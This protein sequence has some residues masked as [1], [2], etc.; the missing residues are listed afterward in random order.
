M[1]RANI[2]TIADLPQHPQNK[3]KRGSPPSLKL[4]ETPPTKIFSADASPKKAERPLPPPRQPNTALR[5]REHLTPA[6]VELLI[7]VARKRGRYGHRDA[8]AILI[9]YTHGLRISELVTLTWSQ[10]DFAEGVIHVR[11]LKGSR[12]STQPLRGS[13]IRALRQLRREWP[14][15]QFLFQTERGGPMTGDNFRKML[16]AAGKAAGFPWLVHPHMLRHACGYKL[17]N[18]GT[19]I[20]T[21]QMYLGHKSISSTAIYTELAADRFNGLWQD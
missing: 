13:E 7:S 6:E 12:P 21:I 19:D 9:A 17:V 18:Q 11:R 15:G 8:T 10:I 3:S 1:A 20:R 4:A 14:D 16:A 2:H 5:P